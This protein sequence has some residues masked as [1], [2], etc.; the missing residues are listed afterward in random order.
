MAGCGPSILSPAP[1][2]GNSASPAPPPAISILL[3]T[4]PHAITLDALLQ[5]RLVVQGGCLFVEGSKGSKTGVAWP[6]GSRW[7]A[8]RQA[9]VIKGVEVAS[10]GQEV[11]VGGGLF[12]VTVE[13]I[14]DFEWINPPLPQCL[15]DYFWIA[16]AISTGPAT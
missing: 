13:T 5:G 11:R 2:P 10:A 12:D 15:G 7:D 1:T 6:A 8:L 16:G 3:P 4:H 14:N 9:I